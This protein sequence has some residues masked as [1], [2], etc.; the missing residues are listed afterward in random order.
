MHPSHNSYPFPVGNPS[1]LHQSCS[2]V[3]YETTS[4]SL[5]VGYLIARATEQKKKVFALYCGDTT[6]KLS[7]IIKGDVGVE[8]F[9]YKT[10]EDV[11]NILEAALGKGA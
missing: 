6:E 4:P 2:F 11:D 10:E 3:A 8:V 5:G 7:G 9:T 1:L